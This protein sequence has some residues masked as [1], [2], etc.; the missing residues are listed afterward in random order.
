MILSLNIYY[1]YHS[2]VARNCP[3]GML[4]LLKALGIFSY[5]CKSYNVFSISVINND[6]KQLDSHG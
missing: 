6:E 5:E 2:G 3:R 4:S 1:Q